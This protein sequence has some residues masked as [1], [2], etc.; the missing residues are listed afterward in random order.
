[1]N[2]E[3]QYKFFPRT[4]LIKVSLKNYFSG[5]NI[6]EKLS[7]GSDMYVEY[8]CLAEHRK[9]KI[10]TTNLVSSISKRWNKVTK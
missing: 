8:K 3:V 5:Q 9:D 6:S 4:S 2:S 1:M 10:Y 7:S